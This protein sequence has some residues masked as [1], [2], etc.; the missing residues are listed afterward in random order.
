[1]KLSQFHEDRIEAFDGLTHPLGEFMNANAAVE[2]I[3][4]LKTAARLIVAGADAD[5]DQGRLTHAID[6]LRASIEGLNAA[7]DIGHAKKRRLAKDEAQTST[8]Q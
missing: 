1:M 8:K 6:C 3:E 2:L 4:A 7:V 5:A